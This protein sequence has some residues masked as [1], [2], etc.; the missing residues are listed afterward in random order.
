MSLSI[1]HDD[2]GSTRDAQLRA[3]EI[4]LAK[5]RDPEPRRAGYTP[6]RF[7]HLKILDAGDVLGLGCRVQFVEPADEE[8]AHGTAPC[9]PD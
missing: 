1:I 8:I 9:S 7:R 4:E 5:Q 2:L 6:S 3:V